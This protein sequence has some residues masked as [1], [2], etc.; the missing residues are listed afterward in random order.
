MEQ[1]V[2]TTG[3]T[4]PLPPQTNRSYEGG[5]K[6]DLNGGNLSLSAAIFQVTQ[7]NARSSDSVGVYT[8]TGTVRVNGARAGIAG[9]VTDKLQMFG[10]YTHLDATIT[11]G[12]A[13]GTAGKTPANT[14][15]DSASLWTSY[16]LT[17]QWELAGGAS[18]S[19]KRFANNTDL[20]AVSGYTRWDAMVAYHQPKY[21]VRFN[22]FNLFNKYYYDALISSDGG[23]AVPGVA[24]SASVTVAYRF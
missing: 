3:G 7:Y 6:W 15:K 12:I 10:G 2:S 13:P 20:V 4:Q 1:L 23:R 11:D 17:K 21:D 19:A 5:G 18:Y 22:V 8:A 9:R 24:R 14:P 16:A